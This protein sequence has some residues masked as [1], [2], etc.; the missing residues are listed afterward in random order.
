MPKPLNEAQ[1]QAARERTRRWVRDNPERKREGDAKWR[2][3]NLAKKR[4]ADAR[5]QAAN[6]EKRRVISA[7]YYA[8]HPDR[9][10]AANA[11]WRDANREQVRNVQRLWE[12]GQLAT[13]VQYRLRKQL[14]IRLNGALRGQA[15]RGSAVSE[16]G[17]S[18]AELVSY[19]EGLWTIGMTWESYGS[20]GWH[21]DHIVPLASFDLTDP[22]QLAKACHYT[23]LQ[24]L[25]WMDNL[26]K[27]DNE[28]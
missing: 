9:A 25:W 13:N 20:G 23:N 4:A 26:V 28:Q 21:I 12:R 19:L 24:P 1:R 8:T 11:C 6:P 3:A 16:L 7:R 17:C 10:R 18:V 15:K 2:Q 22:D 14:R 27:G 5:W